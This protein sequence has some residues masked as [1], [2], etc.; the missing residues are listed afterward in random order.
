M[1]IIADALGRDL[2]L[3]VYEKA[4][5][6]F[7]RAEYEKEKFY[8]AYGTDKP[9]EQKYAKMCEDFIERAQETRLRYWRRTGR[10]SK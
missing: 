5:T 10:L 1:R 8:E 3:Q 6:T 2:A 4:R 7:A 9:L